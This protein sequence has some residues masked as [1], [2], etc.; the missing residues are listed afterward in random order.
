MTLLKWASFLLYTAVLAWE[1]YRSGMLDLRSI[2]AGALVGAAFLVLEAVGA[3]QGWL[4]I[5]LS[6]GSA[7]LWGILLLILSRLSRDALGKGDGLCFL[8]FAVWWGFIRVFSLLFLSLLLSALAGMG[9]LLL[10]RK[11]RKDSLPLMPFLWGA[12]LVLCLMDFGR[13][14]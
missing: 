6:R 12:A 10:R 2:A 3:A 8:S 5:L 11:K 14:L 7:L 4:S 9:L 1:D 13:G